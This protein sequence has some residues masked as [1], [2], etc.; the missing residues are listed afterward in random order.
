MDQLDILPVEKLVVLLQKALEPDRS[1]YVEELIRRF[2]PLLR[3]AWRRGGFHIE[4]QD[5]VQD[6]FVRL[7]K[8]LP[9]LRNPKAFPGFF[10]RVALS[11]A[12]S[13]ARK[14]AQPDTVEFVEKMVIEHLEE[15]LVL[16]IFLRSYIEELPEREREVITLTFLKGLPNKTVAAKLNITASA[17]RATKTRGLNRLRAIFARDAEVLEKMG[18]Q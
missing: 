16:G 5:F 6:V 12:V 13:H 1:A 7:F 18:G 9:S 4:Y 17:V 3:R 10:R 15:E 8:G 11:V 2:E 14:E